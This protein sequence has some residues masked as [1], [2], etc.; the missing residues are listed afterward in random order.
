M[1]TQKRTTLMATAWA[2]IAVAIAWGNPLPALAKTSGA[3]SS[4]DG[5]VLNLGS[6][7]PNGVLR[8]SGKARGAGTLDLGAAKLQVIS[9]LS[10]RKGALELVAAG[11]GGPLL[12]LH[13]S[14]K[15]GSSTTDAIFE[16]EPSPAGPNVRITIARS[17]SNTDEY[18]FSIQVERA[19]I[20]ADP[21]CEGPKGTTE[22][23]TRLSLSDGVNQPVKLHIRHNWQ[24]G[25]NKLADPAPVADV[26]LGGEAKSPE[27]LV[28]EMALDLALDV[29]GDQLNDALF[30]GNEIDYQTLLNDFKEILEDALLDNDIQLATGAVNGF[31]NFLYQEELDFYGYNT[32]G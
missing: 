8:L 3:A 22:R 16:S 11:D 12:P 19:L 14:A 4:L 17:A 20:A 26:P 32:S 30:P 28:G 13:L 5:Q 6:G 7:K 25:K 10:E 21:A 23:R 9:F 29:A 2:M 27:A 31:T 24:C 15:K 18:D 1:K